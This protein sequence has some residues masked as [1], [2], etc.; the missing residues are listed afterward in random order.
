MP[1]FYTLPTA[2]LV[3]RLSTDDGQDI[4]A[5]HNHG[6]SVS[7]TVYTPRP[8]DPDADADNLS[9]PETRIADC[10]SAVG[11]AV[12]PGTLADLSQHLQARIVRVVPD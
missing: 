5:V 3:E 8:D 10:G 11:L 7:Y 4:I 6:S 2:H 9:A 1:V 12:L